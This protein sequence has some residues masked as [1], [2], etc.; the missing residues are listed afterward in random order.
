M[1]LPAISGA[2]IGAPR[3]IKAVGSSWMGGNLSVS[4]ASSGNYFYR[5]NMPFPDVLRLG[6][7]ST[8]ASY[9][10]QIMFGYGM[11]LGASEYRYPNAWPLGSSFAGKTAP[12]IT[13]Y[14]GLSTENG[15][16]FMLPSNPSAFA[17][18]VKFWKQA[19]NTIT[20]EGKD[21][22]VRIKGTYTPKGPDMEFFASDGE[23]VDANIW[24]DQ[25]V[26]TKT[27]YPGAGM[28][29]TAWL[30][31]SGTYPYN[32]HSIV[33]Y[34][35]NHT[36]RVLLASGQTGYYAPGTAGK[37]HWA[38]AIP[39]E[40]AAEKPTLKG[41]IFSNAGS[42]AI[43]GHASDT[44]GAGVF[45]EPSLGGDEVRGRRLYIYDDVNK[46]F[47]QT[48]GEASSTIRKDISFNRGDPVFALGPT[49]AAW[50]ANV[51]KDEMPGEFL[52]V[53][54]AAVVYL[55]VDAAPVD[56]S[57]SPTVD[58]PTL[59]N[60]RNL[61]VNALTDPAVVGTDREQPF[62]ARIGEEVPPSLDPQVVY[63]HLTGQ[64]LG[65]R[66][67]RIGKPLNWMDR[68]ANAGKFDFKAGKWQAGLDH[69][70]LDYN[71]PNSGAA[72]KSLGA[73]I[74]FGPWDVPFGKHLH[75]A[76]AFVGGVPDRAL[77]Q[78]MGQFYAKKKWLTR[79]ELD[80]LSDLLTGWDYLQTYAY[81]KNT[82]TANAGKTFTESDKHAF[83]NSA[84]D[85][86]YKQ[87]GIVKQVWAA[88]LA[89]GRFGPSYPAFVGWPTTVSYTGGPGS[90]ILT[91]SAVPG[92]A[93]Y[94]V[95]RQVGNANKQPRPIAAATGLTG[96]T[97]TDTGL[98][99]G[100]FYYYSV[101]AVDAQGREGAWMMA[102]NTN[103]VI[104]TRVPSGADWRDKVRIVP[105]PISRRGGQEKDGGF[106]YT[107]GA[108]N[109][110]QVQFVNIPGKC[111]IN[112][113]T[114]TGDLVASVVHTS[115][116]G[117]RGWY[118]VT[119]NNQRPVSGIY[120]CHIRN[121]AAPSETKLLKLVILR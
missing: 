72:D 32:G 87:V 106:N 3:S 14:T 80:Q 115:G 39:T 25:A 88:G 28:E 10:M 6:Q 36:G 2:Q 46:M 73:A 63:N 101:T 89:A 120:L 58:A 93:K 27:V 86:L 5:D 50:N 38:T 68:P 31:G 57:A 99:R 77:N 103:P 41:F 108:L 18:P 95:Y 61:G 24:S 67:A 82:F 85:S 81:W 60:A 113:F 59:A 70:T 11:V 9:F 17:S 116:T 16:G 1:A 12:F 30:Y 64:G 55:H 74:T 118:L 62:Q 8:Y 51:L 56:N 96:T 26:T 104:P 4:G 79:A 48:D 52:T 66:S 111:T 112:I 33:T 34:D 75:I 44:Y 83:I 37:D 107:G 54:T 98:D 23:K 71:K 100:V 29:V 90:A 20:V 76:Y 78:I 19:A 40:I 22:T 13:G 7:G 102:Q 47:Y 121:D 49:F 45:G 117:D 35:L 53:G 42:I 97:F 119:D 21:N 110:N 105:N 109:Q 92:A 69:A 15:P 65:A 91:W 114:T 43:P 94:N 84:I